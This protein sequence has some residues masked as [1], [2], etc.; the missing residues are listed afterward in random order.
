MALKGS[1]E[2]RARMKAIQT[3][4]KP[5]GREW[6]DHTSDAA[7]GMVPVRTGQLRGSIKRKNSTLKRA[8]VS[9]RYTAFFVDAGTKRHEIVPKR[10]SG[11]V[12]PA[13]GRT[14]FAKKVEHPGSRPQPFRQRAS[15]EGLRRTPLAEH[16]IKLWNS[17]RPAR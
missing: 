6:A 17:G 16:L 9:A 8:T 5:L 2:L 4:F 10:S 13:G 12:F 3:T 11:L 7:R 1:A 15:E 14:V